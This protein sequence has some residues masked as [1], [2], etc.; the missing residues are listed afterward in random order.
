MLYVALSNPSKSPN[1]RG[2]PSQPPPARAR[3]T[4]DS[5]ATEDEAIHER[6]CCH[7]P[8]TEE[9]KKI[10]PR[11]REP[12]SVIP[13]A[14]PVK[15]QTL[16]AYHTYN[17]AN[18]AF[19]LCIAA[20]TRPNPNPSRTRVNL[21]FSIP[22][23]ADA[24]ADAAAAQ[25]RARRR[26]RKRLAEKVV[27]RWKSFAREGIAEARARAH[28]STNPQRRA[29]ARW[30]AGA[31]AL[32][33]RRLLHGSAA[34]AGRRRFLAESR[35]LAAWAAAAR[36][37]AAARRAGRDAGRVALAHRS[38]AVAT[39]AL[40]RWRGAASLAAARRGMEAAALRA[41]ASG[42]V[43]SGLAG[44]R[45]NALKHRLDVFLL[46]RGV[47]GRRRLLGLRGFAALEAAVLRAAGDRDVDAEAVAGRVRAALALWG[48]RAS[49]LRARRAVRAEQARIFVC[50]V[51]L[52]F[53]VFSLEQQE[54]RGWVRTFL[55]HGLFLALGLCHLQQCWVGCVYCVCTITVPYGPRRT[56]FVKLLF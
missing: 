38:R 35:G 31:A 19:F 23:D 40:H 55:L 56:F 53:L 17:D 14:Q 29:L 10:G 30:R 32:R 47:V 15:P 36:A 24:D 25:Q 37:G 13:E 6:Y 46:D 7:T 12:Q 28:A 20:S 16:V 5:S 51:S 8:T 42:R 54:G 2:C 18:R 4:H 39:T 3:A 11:V 50:F 33:S 9:K 45:R 48:R 52:I 21:F 44:L 26:R 1:T 22:Q 34:A 43:Y 27:A 41:W 49:V